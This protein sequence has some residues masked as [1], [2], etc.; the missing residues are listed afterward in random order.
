MDLRDRV[1]AGAHWLRAGN[2]RN[3]SR[4]GVRRAG[5]LG[6]AALGVAPLLA[7]CGGSDDATA[8]KA[9]GA[10]TSASGASPTAAT[11]AASPTQA[12]AS[13][14]SGSSGGASPTVASA[15]TPTT[16]AT[17]APTPTALAESGQG[18]TLLLGVVQEPDSLDPQRTIAGASYTV[19][20]NIFDCLITTNSSGEF[21][22]IVAEKYEI[23]TD[24]VSFTWTIRDGIAAHDGSTLTAKDVKY[25]F[26]RATDAT[27]PSQAA[28]FISAY[29]SAE[30]V[31]DKT[32]AMTLSEPSAPFLTNIA[33]EYFG[34]L[35][36]AAVE[37]AGDDFSTNPVGS[38][39][40]TFKSWTPGE[41][42][43]LEPFADYINNRS[44]VTGKGAPAAD[45]LQ[46]LVIPEA[47][48]L[49]AAFETG[50]VN[51]VLPIP[52]QEVK[53]YQDNPDYEV[54]ITQ[55][56][57]NIVFLGFAT[58][59]GEGDTYDPQYVAPFDDL[60]VRQ[61]VAYGVDVDEIIEG[62]YAGL[63]ERDYGPMP[64]GLFA[65][66]PSIEQFGYHFDADK[67]N[68]LLDEAGWTMGSD[69]VREKDGKKLEIEFWGA[70]DPTGDK[71]AQV[72]QNQL[73][74]IGMKLNLNLIEIGT[75]IAQIGGSNAQMYSIGV[76]W[77]EADILVVM[78][79]NVPFGTGFYRP[80]N[81]IDAIHKARQTY[82]KDERKQLYFEAQKILLADLPIV[83]L[84][85]QS[86]ALG[87]R[88]EVK[89][90]VIGPL[91]SLLV[92]DGY[93]ES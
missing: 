46:F 2:E 39:P 37:A 34:I 23:G 72:V 7:A 78:A 28:S 84:W 85:S 18:G 31:D 44:F 12:S 47:Q 90:V 15:T 14:T 64:T 62:V 30:L 38:G 91:N 25:T 65:Y 42:V 8:T 48:T 83:P 11:S 76:G 1:N 9:A 61:A 92:T 87:T 59:K 56:S 55:G 3:I 27:N 52:S 80:A 40:W 71:A 67:A 53:N 73:G 69:G 35:P 4:R 58:I 86:D 77:P 79:D 57:S 49:L 20:A 24:G 10:A 29:K 70:T 17:F 5:A 45:E 54:Q 88:K 63:A 43:V 60:K 75:F 82:V 6:V 22:P 26:D 33:V 50:E 21:D 68:G 41:Q 51:V 89:G 32:I 93:V 36:Q 74:K 19:F 13:P 81:Y 16:A 66:D